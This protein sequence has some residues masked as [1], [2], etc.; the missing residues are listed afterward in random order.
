[1]IA[2]VHARHTFT[3][4]TYYPRAFM[5]Q[6]ERRARRPVTSRRVQITVTNAGCLDFNQDFAGARR[7]EFGILD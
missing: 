3:D 6:Y 5:A 2:C 4:F 7:L 1:V